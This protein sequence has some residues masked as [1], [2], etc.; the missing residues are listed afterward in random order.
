ME[1]VFWKLESLFLKK[2]QLII[3]KFYFSVI[4]HTSAKLIEIQQKSQDMDCMNLEDN[5][6]LATPLTGLVCACSYYENFLAKLTNFLNQNITGHSILK[7]DHL[8]H[9]HF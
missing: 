8:C 9:L 7:T 5:W 4:N 3:S 2:V 6:S 1:W